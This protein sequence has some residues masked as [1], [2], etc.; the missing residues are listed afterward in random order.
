M[1]HISVPMP[2][3]PRSKPV[4]DWVLERV[5]SLVNGNNAEFPVTLALG[6]TLLSGTMISGQKYLAGIIAQFAPDEQSEQRQ[7]W[8]SYLEELTKSNAEHEVG[9]DV[10]FVHLRDVSLFRSDSPRIEKTW[11]RCRLSEVAAFTLDRGGETA[12]FEASIPIGF[13]A[14]RGNL[15]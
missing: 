9:Q 13:T 10:N 6:G 11:W 8:N 5:V 7:F 14:G 1:D 3:I 2:Y 4:V 15:S 12:F